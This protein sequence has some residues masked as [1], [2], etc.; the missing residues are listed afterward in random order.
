MYPNYAIKST[1]KPPTYTPPYSAPISNF[2]D[3]LLITEQNSKITPISF[4]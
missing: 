1:Y 2:V 4:N 3:I